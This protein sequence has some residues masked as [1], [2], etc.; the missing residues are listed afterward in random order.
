MQPNQ[1][2]NKTPGSEAFV[3]KLGS[4][5]VDLADNLAWKTYLECEE[6]FIRDLQDMVPSIPLASQNY[7]ERLVFLS[8]MV[9]GLKRM[10]LRRRD[11]LEEYKIKKE[12]DRQNAG[13]TIN[14]AGTTYGYTPA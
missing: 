10:I 9:E 3:L 14:E 1:P 13:T 12:E 6:T 7:P 11:I 8:G 2:S 5:L 4:V